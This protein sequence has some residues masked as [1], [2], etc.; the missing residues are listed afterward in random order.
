MRL[1][2]IR[3]GSKQIISTSGEFDVLQMILESNIKRCASENA[4]LP[5]RV[6]CEISH[7]LER[8]TYGNLSL[9]D[10]FYSHEADG[11]T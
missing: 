9:I 4:R 11:N 3:N 8:R 10:A 2:T 5:R 1:T 7:Q 6:D